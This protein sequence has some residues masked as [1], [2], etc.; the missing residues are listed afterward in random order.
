MSRSSPKVSTKWGTVTSSASTEIQQFRLK[1]SDGGI[2]SS[3]A[4]YQPVH[5]QCSSRRYMNHGAHE[6]LPS[7]RATLR[8]EKRSSTPPP[9]RHAVTNW[10]PNGWLKVCHNISR[11]ST[12]NPKS[13]VR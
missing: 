4:S 13:G 7:R 10:I 12:S 2:V 5:S 1:Y 8:L 11:S 6:Q 9:H 3:G